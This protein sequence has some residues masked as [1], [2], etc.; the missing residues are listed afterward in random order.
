MKLVYD[1]RSSP[2]TWN[3]FDA[4]LVGEMCRL[5]RGEELLE[6]VCVPGPR[7]GFRDDD[8]PP[9]GGAER[10]RWHENIVRPMGLL[11]PSCGAPIEIVPREGAAGVGLGS[12]LHGFHTNV[13][14]ARR[15]LAPFRATQ[16]K[17][18]P[19]LVTISLRETGWWKSRQSN[20]DDW[21]VVGRAIRATGLD[22]IF[23]RDAAKAGEPLE[24][25]AIAPTASVNSVARANLYASAAMNL[26]ISNG[27]LWFAWFMAAPV[28]IFDPIHD[29][30]PCANAAH[31][32][33]CGLE[34]GQQLP[35]AR[36]GQR[37]VWEKARPSAVLAAFDEAMAHA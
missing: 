27:P 21:L 6:A 5:D 17:R 35:N 7:E 8:L 4:L 11:L 34:P 18:D 19:R 24:D 23:V 32:R 2:P 3:A 29:D 1:Y 14:A 26:G 15:G 10:L 22:V 31:F 13:E 20:L 37:I 33:A 12:H 28:L 30:E 36:P 25:F 9:F 16:A